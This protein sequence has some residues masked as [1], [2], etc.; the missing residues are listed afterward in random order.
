[1][2]LSYMSAMGA[3]ITS[4]LPFHYKLGMVLTAATYNHMLPS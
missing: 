1:M 3:I 2:E 4:S